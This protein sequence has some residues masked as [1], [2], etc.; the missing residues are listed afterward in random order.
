[1]ERKIEEE[2]KEI[3]EGDVSAIVGGV[4][5]NCVRRRKEDD[6]ILYFIRSQNTD[7]N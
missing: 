6:A 2:K 1:M 5:L 7:Y 4:L 3:D